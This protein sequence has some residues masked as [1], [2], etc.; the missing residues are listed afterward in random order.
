MLW[1]LWRT[2]RRMSRRLLDGV[3]PEIVDDMEQFV[4]SVTGVQ[5]ITGLRVRWHGIS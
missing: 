3:E 1:L 4:H 5:E 2:A